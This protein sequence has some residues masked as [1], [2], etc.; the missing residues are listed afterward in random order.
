MS[1]IPTAIG[2]TL[3]PPDQMGGFLPV[4]MTFV[5][6]LI[7]GVDLALLLRYQKLTA[8]QYKEW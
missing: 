4:A 6:F 3:L 8:Q 1:I 5:A 2:I 7:I